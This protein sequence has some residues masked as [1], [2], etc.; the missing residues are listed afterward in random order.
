MT[1][2]LLTVLFGALLG[3][4]GTLAVQRTL[5]RHGVRERETDFTWPGKPLRYIDADPQTVIRA[6]EGS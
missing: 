5:S 2:L 3:V 6:T 4:A 1:A